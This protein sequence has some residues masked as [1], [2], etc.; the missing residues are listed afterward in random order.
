[1]SFDKI[2]DLTAGVY[3]Y[4]YN[5]IL[6]MYSGVY[7]YI[8]SKH[9][10]SAKTSG[11]CITQLAKMGIDPLNDRTRSWRVL[12]HFFKRGCNTLCTKKTGK[13]N[14]KNGKKNGENRD[15]IYTCTHI[16]RCRRFHTWN[17]ASIPLRPPIMSSPPSS[18]MPLAWS[19]VVGKARSR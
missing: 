3:F 10:T 18:P 1:M 2:F 14:G 12:K 7:I 15:K 17:A 19:L 6:S 11:R 4:F 5:I 8:Y 9:K 13:K 16:K